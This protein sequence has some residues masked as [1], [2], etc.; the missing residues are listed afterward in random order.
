MHKD[1]SPAGLKSVT[2]IY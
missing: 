2:Q 1:S